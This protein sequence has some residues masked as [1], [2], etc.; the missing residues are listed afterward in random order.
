MVLLE[1]QKEMYRQHELGMIDEVM[2]VDRFEGAYAT[3]ADEINKLVQSHIEVKMK[4]VD[5]VSRYAN[6]DLSVDMD[7]LPGKKA[8][9]TNSIDDVK[10]NL[11]ALN[12]EILMLVEA[13]TAGQL[14]IRGDSGKFQYSFKDMVNGINDTLDAVVGPLNVAA[15]YVDSIAHGYIPDKITD[16]YRGDFNEIK[17]NLNQCIDTLNGLLESQ[18]EMYRQHELGMIDE[19]MPVESFRVPMQPWLM[20]SINLLNLIL[21]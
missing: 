7:R 20:R 1:S 15:E 13:A 9:I 14:D 2:P 4:I 5:V 12:N 8:L 6:G 18:K 16:E 10:A 3:M 11:L 17:D 19:V 21:K